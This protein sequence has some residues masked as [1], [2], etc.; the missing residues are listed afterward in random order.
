MKMHLYG[1]NPSIWEVAVLGVTPPMNGAP[2]SEQVQDYFRNAQ[3]VRVIT[4][5]VCAQEF[6]N[7]CNV[8]IDMAIWDTSREAHEGTDEVKEGKMDLLQEELDNFVMNDEE[9]MSQMYDRL[10]ILVSNIRSLGSIK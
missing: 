6:N 7:V 4:S 8:E 3:A 10:M 2:T 9:T 1:L 5:S